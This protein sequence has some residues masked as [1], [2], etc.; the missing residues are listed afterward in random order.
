MLIAVNAKVDADNIGQMLALMQRE[1]GRR[2]YG[3]D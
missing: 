2:A 3:P 1:P